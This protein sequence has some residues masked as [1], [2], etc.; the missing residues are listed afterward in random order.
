MRKIIDKIKNY[1]K[2][3]TVYIWDEFYDLMTENDELYDNPTIVEVTY[4]GFRGIIDVDFTDRRRESDLC[5]I[6]KFY[7]VCKIN[8]YGGLSEYKKYSIYGRQ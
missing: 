3:R 5:D 1:F 7:S 4:S 6:A 2:H 8:K